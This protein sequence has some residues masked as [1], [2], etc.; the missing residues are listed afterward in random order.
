MLKQGEGVGD[1][2][3][4]A[5]SCEIESKG[6]RIKLQDQHEVVG[7]SHSSLLSHEMA[8]LPLV[9]F[10]LLPRKWSSMFE[11]SVSPPSAGQAS[12]A[13]SLVWS[14]LPVSTVTPQPWPLW[15]VENCRGRLLALVGLQ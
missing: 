9:W 14:Y 8:R 2:E 5:F 3:G 11:S 13:L 15:T 6:T 12:T 4:E 1:V 10:L 7:G